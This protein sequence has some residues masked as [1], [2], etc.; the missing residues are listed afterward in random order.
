ME[1]SILHFNEVC[2][3]VFDKLVA[4]FYKDPTN[5]ADFV[6]GITDE[7]HS[8]GLMLIQE[9]LEDM[10]QMLRDSG[11]RKTKWV[12]E[13]TPKEPNKSLVTSLGTVHFK[14][15]L[16]ANK[17]NGEMCYL[18]D[19][20]MGI[21]KHERITEDAVAGILEEAV[22]T[23]YRRGGE[24]ASIMDKVSK[25]TVKNV[26]HG[27]KFPQGWKEPAKKRKVDY[28]YV[29]ADED[30]ISLQYRESKGDIIR[31]P[32]GRKNNGAMSKLIYVHE[33]I[34]PEAPMSK[35]NRLINPHYFSRTAQG[36]SNNELWDGVYRYIEANY[37]VDN[38]KKIYLSS[39]GG[40]WISSGA[41]RIHG[42]THLLDQYHLEQH[43]NVISRHMLDSKAEV[44]EELHRIICKGTKKDFI[45][46]VSELKEYLSESNKIKRFEESSEYILNNWSASKYRLKKMEGKVGSSTEG[47]V[48]HVLS[49]RMSTNAL[50]WSLKGADK[51]AQLRAYY[52]N[53]GNM[54]ELVRYQK[55]ELSLAAGGEYQTYIDKEKIAKRKDV[56]NTELY[57]FHDRI[58]AHLAVDVKKKVYFQEHIWIDI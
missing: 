3:G 31:L 53:G 9:T 19:R 46:Y 7:I 36:C 50:G 8:W 4:D 33:G 5:I 40:G 17:K 2:V 25:Q 54:L 47:H 44:K 14:K 28:L 48:S 32:S 22:Q 51:M 15:T 42:I 16:F 43:L 11:K 29:E 58:Q 13:K 39:D 38:I 26:I 57:R 45:S 6:T 34:E 21:E 10:D 27:L 30:H 35:R 55:E 49:C 24:A 41:R 56:S 18:L 1:K 37:D 52:L 12:I 20:I 23:S